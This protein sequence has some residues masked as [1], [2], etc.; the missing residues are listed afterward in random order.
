MIGP[1]LTD[2]R[3][4]TDEFIQ[5]FRYAEDKTKVEEIL[6][7]RQQT[8]ASSM[9]KVSSAA[10]GGGRGEAVAGRGGRGS[11]LS[12][13]RPGRGSPMAGRGSPMGGRGIITSPKPDTT[14]SIITNSEVNEEEI[15]IT[16]DISIKSVIDFVQPTS[17]S[18][19]IQD[20]DIEVWEELVR[21]EN[22]KKSNNDSESDD[23]ANIRGSVTM[24]P[25]SA[26]VTSD[27]IKSIRNSVNNTSIST[28]NDKKCNNNVESLETNDLVSII[29]TTND[30][31]EIAPITVLDTVQSGRKSRRFSKFLPHNDYNIQIEAESSNTSNIVEPETSTLNTS[32]VVEPETSTLQT[33]IKNENVK[34]VPV[35]EIS[36]TFNSKRGSV[37]ASPIG[38]KSLKEKFLATGTDGSVIVVSNNTTASSSTTVPKRRNTYLLSNQTDS[39][40]NNNNN[41]SN[42]S[43][44]EQ[45]YDKNGVID[46]EK[47]LDTNFVDSTGNYKIY[48]Y[49]V[50]VERNKLKMYDGLS[51]S[52]LEL[53]LDDKEFV[54]KFGLSKEEYNK[55]PKWRK[56]AQ[57]KALLLF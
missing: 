46:T 18:E 11:G 41:N 4:K 1:R 3:S 57:K 23:E 16:N 28:I 47:L 29:A 45:K 49:D 43:S 20:T 50:L 31:I 10:A 15:S 6:K 55:L 19:L 30:V 44:E 26:H 32:N 39:G 21:N 27:D 17:T 53:H 9:F 42:T 2:P 8:L 12:V 36:A 52:D 34:E 38:I 54:N 22:A 35:T 40:N 7:A 5:I 37:R 25:F 14:T 33:E 51:Q 56:I 48:S 24:R 13:A